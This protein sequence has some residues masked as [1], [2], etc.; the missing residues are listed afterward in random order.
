MLGDAREDIGE[1]GVG[2]DAGEL[3]RSDHRIDHRRALAGAIGAGK[4]PG[5]SPECDSAQLALGG[6]VREADPSVVEE[7]RKGRPSLEHVVHRLG[8]LGM[9]RETRARGTHPGLERVDQRLD[10]LPARGQPRLGAVAVDR[11]LGGED[12]IDAGH[13]L[14]GERGL[15]QLGELEMLASAVRLMSCSA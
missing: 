4:R 13:G 5:S 1:P 15:G 10:V 11:T 7:A 12:R 8:G 3:A 2:I 9:A 14:D 6:I